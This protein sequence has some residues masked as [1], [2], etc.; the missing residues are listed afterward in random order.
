MSPTSTTISLSLSLF[1]F[2]TLLALPTTSAFPPPRAAPPL[3]KRCTNLLSNPSFETGIDPWLAMLTGSFTDQRGIYTSSSGGH[4]G[5]NFYYAHGNSSVDA[6]LTLSQS[7]FAIGSAAPGEMECST[8]VASRR[9]GN[10]GS[11]RVE[12]FL[13]GISCGTQYLGTTGWTKVGGKVKPSSDQTHTIA[14]VVNSDEA[15]DQGWS[16]WVDDVTVG[17]GC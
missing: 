2:W 16:L 15:G 17:Q 9:P 8:W 14:I 13:D 10:V 5:A 6:T 12:V 4:S 1:F 7:G 11:T 3:A